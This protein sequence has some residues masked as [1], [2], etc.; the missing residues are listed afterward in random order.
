MLHD[1]EA[2]LEIPGHLGRDVPH[3]QLLD[4]VQRLHEGFLHRVPGLHET[5]HDGLE[6]SLETV[7]IVADL[8]QFTVFGKHDEAFHSFGHTLHG[9]DHL[10][11]GGDQC[12]VFASPADL[13]Q[14]S[15]VGHIPIGDVSSYAD[16]VSDV[17]PYAVDPFRDFGEDSQEG[18]FNLLG[19]VVDRHLLKDRV[20]FDHA[21]E[22]VDT[23]VQVV[24]NLVEVP[25]ILICDLRGNLPLADPVHVLGRHVQ[26]AD[27]RV[28]SRVD[29]FDDLAEIPL[30][31]GGI[32]PVIKLPIDGGL[33][34]GLRV[35]DEKA[36]SVDTAVQ[37]VLD[38]VEV[39]TVLIG[40]LG[41]NLPL[42]DPVHVLGRHVQ[43]ADHGVQDP[44]EA[45][46]NLPELEVDLLR[47]HP[48]V[49]LSTHSR[50]DEAS[51]LPLEPLNNG[52]HVLVEEEGQTK[53][54]EDGD[55]GK[56]H[57]QLDGT[58]GQAGVV[59]GDPL[60]PSDLVLDKIFQSLFLNFRGA[61]RFACHQGLG[62]LDPSGF[63]VGDDGVQMGPVDLSG[64]DK[65][66]V[67]I[68]TGIGGNRLLILLRLFQNTPGEGVDRLAKLL[69]LESALSLHHIPNVDSDL[70]EVVGNRPQGRY[71]NGHVFIEKSIGNGDFLN[72]GDPDPTDDNQQDQQ[73]PNGD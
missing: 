50:F 24:L 37:V 70:L 62:L 11:V 18:T 49:E 41:G 7:Q 56:D 68:P 60:G 32:G 47:V 1:Q 45:F 53:A 63:Q 21:L 71:R 23:A 59:F 64:V 55:D 25:P 40:D 15:Q 38:L 46:G 36:D 6:G 61:L 29:P 5:L 65:L 54:E 67:D 9:F 27:H 48:S 17:G 58:T 69:S 19:K 44:V 22:A 51:R 34:E 13:L 39:P 42:A 35:R 14:V 33:R 4:N 10:D 2:S 12:V 31:P 52:V 30:V 66:L 43:G 28:Q 73:D 8:I 16:G 3:R 26:R 57:H 20:G 72:V